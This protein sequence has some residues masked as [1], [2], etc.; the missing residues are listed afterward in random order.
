MLSIAFIF[1]LFSYLIIQC[2]IYLFIYQ[3]RFYQKYSEGIKYFRHSYLKLGH[4]INLI[5]LIAD[6]C[7]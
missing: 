7:N 2:V 3:L 6:A 5:T 4:S 1:L